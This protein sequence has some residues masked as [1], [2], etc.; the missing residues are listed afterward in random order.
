MIG[1]PDHLVPPLERQRHTR[2]VLEI[3]QRVDELRPHAQRGVQF[4]GPHAV[5]VHRHVDVLGL[6]RVPCLQRA[7]VGGSFDNEMIAGIDEDLAD[8]IER[9]LRA[10]GD[11]DV[12]RFDDD[13]VARRV[14]RDHLAK[15]AIAFGGAVLKRL[16]SVFLEQPAGG[17]LESIHREDVRRGQPAGERDEV[18]LVG[19]LEEFT[20]RG[21]AHALRALRETL[22]PRGLHVFL[23]EGVASPTPSGTLCGACTRQ[24]RVHDCDRR[25]R[26][27]PMLCRKHLCRKE[28]R[29]RASLFRTAARRSAHCLCWTG[30]NGSPFLPS[31]CSG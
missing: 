8:E 25:M 7:E 17:L 12:F 13:A 4:L 11:E 22:C 3:R 19:E 23:R 26:T 9:L 15:R 27:P 30:V 16:G 2:R 21:T 5:L 31:S 18:R 29:H 6:V 28:R 24:G 1:Q 20:D 10:A 14:P